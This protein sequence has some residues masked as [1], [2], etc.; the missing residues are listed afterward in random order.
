M[1]LDS[2][3][4]ERGRAEEREN[5]PGDSVNE[6][7]DGAPGRSDGD[8][9]GDSQGLRDL[10]EKLEGLGLSA[11]VDTFSGGKSGEE[12]I[13]ELIVTNPAGRERGQIRIGDDGAVTWEYFG[14]LSEVGAGRV[15]DDV[16]A[17]LRATEVQF[18]QDQGHR[19][20]IAG[21]AEQQLVYLNTHWGRPYAISRPD[22]PDGRWKAKARFG[23][24]DELDDFSAAGL[25]EK[26]REH[27]RA[28]RPE[29]L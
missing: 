6:E 18:L 19:A 4:G 11:R 16:T 29:E 15:L 7:K 28:H 9:A 5:G 26:M 10:K 14:D 24:Q 13:E 17:A 3:H 8:V 27:Y 20:D 22:G 1:G 23:K 2:A 21:T 12:L 25:L